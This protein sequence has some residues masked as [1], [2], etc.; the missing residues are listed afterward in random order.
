MPENRDLDLVFGP[1]ELAQQTFAF[2]DERMLNQILGV[3]RQERRMLVNDK[4]VD[5]VIEQVAQSFRDGVV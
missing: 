5:S 4:P 1:M 3:Q 2:N